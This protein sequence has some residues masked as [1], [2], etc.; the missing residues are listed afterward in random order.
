MQL[1]CRA[2]Y[3]LLL[4]L[5]RFSLI[6]FIG[7]PGCG[8]STIGRQIARRLN[9]DFID[10]DVE[11][12]KRAGCTIREF[13]EREGEEKF[14]DVEETTLSDIVSQAIGV[15]STG[16]GSVIRQINRDNLRKSGYVIYLRSTPDELVK[17]LRHDRNRPLLQV[18]DPMQKVRDLFDHRDHLYSET[19]HFVIETGRPSVSS[20][21]N[22][23]VMQ[24]ELAGV[25][26]S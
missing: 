3:Q 24:I 7:L 21:V 15:V 4:L 23:L 2:H 22:T 25:K 10:S 14:R 5:S 9:C 26:Y 1:K 17:R 6:I 18:S 19:A 13:F 16:G 12:E 11:I 20:L 8:K